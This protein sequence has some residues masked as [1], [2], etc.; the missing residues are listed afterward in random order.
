MVPWYGLMMLMIWWYCLNDMYGTMIL[1]MSLM[2]PQRGLLIYVYILYDDDMT[3]EN[4]FTMM[5]RSTTGRDVK[6]VS[7]AGFGLV[8]AS[9]RS[10]VWTKKV[11]KIANI[12]L[13]LSGFG[14]N[15]SK[16]G[17]KSNKS[18]YKFKTKILKQNVQIVQI[19]N[20]YKP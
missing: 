18:N 16:M 6:R 3:W 2:M 5:V 17:Y 1:D 11:K 14:L 10:T 9:R 4:G 7:L 15:G 8:L 20:I 12:I 19:K 13:I